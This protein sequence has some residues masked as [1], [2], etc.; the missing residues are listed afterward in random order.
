MAAIL[1]IDRLARPAKSASG[2]F[3]TIVIKVIDMREPAR[4]DPYLLDSLMPDLVGHDRQPSAFLVYLYLSH[5]AA[6]ER[7]RERRRSASRS[8]PS[9]P[10]S[11]KARCRPGCGRW[12]AAG[13]SGWRRPR[14]PP[15]RRTRCFAPGSGGKGR[16]QLSSAYGGSALPGGGV[17]R[18]HLPRLQDGSD[19]HGHR[20]RRRRPAHS[21][22]LRLLRQRAQLSRRACASRRRSPPPHARRSPRARWA[23]GRSGEGGR[24]PRSPKIPFPSSA[25]ASG[26]PLL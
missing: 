3:D 10:A 1:R 2:P 17:D 21:R 16:L 13:W 23:A 11:R 22:L 8:S 9:T 14:E 24:A 4:F 12:S 25:T 20:R 15:S 26:S 5:R 7:V 19:A 6:R 18:G